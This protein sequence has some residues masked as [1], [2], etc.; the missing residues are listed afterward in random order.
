VENIYVP[1]KL[2][3]R[4]IPYE[5]VDPDSIKIRSF[6]GADSEVMAQVNDSN[7]Y[8][9]F[10]M[11]MNRCLQGIE[12]ERL[13]LGDCVYITLWQAINS[14]SGKVNLDFVC[15]HC[16]KELFKTIDLDKD[17]DSIDLSDQYKQLNI[18]EIGGKELPL[19]LLTVKD[20]ELVFER[21]LQKLPIVLYE[22]A[23]TIENEK[24]VEENLEMLR[25][26]PLKEI[27]KLEAFQDEFNHGPTLLAPYTCDECKQEGKV[28]VPFRFELF[29][30]FK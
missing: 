6:V 30:S 8:R 20:Q 28:E 5:G 27:H 3:S 14:Y 9:K 21:S 2:P 11:I 13:T 10:A 7:L 19:R 22:C 16:F 23:L 18:R 17:L 24:S 25:T 12:A 1:I 15:E 4:C 26:L 29:F